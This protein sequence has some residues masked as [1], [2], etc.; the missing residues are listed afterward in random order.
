MSKEK[1]NP[2]VTRILS[3]VGIIATLAIYM[4]SNANEV[5]SSTY[6]QAESLYDRSHCQDAKE[7]YWSIYV[8][9]YKDCRDKMAWCDYMS[10]KY[11]IN[12]IKYENAFE[13]LLPHL[14][15]NPTATSPE[16][17][18]DMRDLA[19]STVQG[20]IQENQSKGMLTDAEWMIGRWADKDENYIH[21]RTKEGYFTIGGNI[22]GNVA[23]QEYYYSFQYGIYKLIVKDTGESAAEI[24]FFPASEDKV[25]AYNISTGKMYFLIRDREAI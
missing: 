11:Y 1:F 9:D 7:L 16:I 20:V 21:F 10:A 13:L 14:F 5:I 24:I 23:D 25:Y 12:N 4:C 17:L 3:L 15:D 18:D 2:I 19:A 22:Y 8:T 6:A